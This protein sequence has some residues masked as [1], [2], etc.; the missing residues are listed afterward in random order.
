M[1]VVP[2]SSVTGVGGGGS[3]AAASPLKSIPLAWGNYCTRI[4]QPVETLAVA[5]MGGTSKLRAVNRVAANQ[6]KVVLP[7]YYLSQT[8]SGVQ[9]VAITGNI[10]LACSIEFPRGSGNRYPFLF[11]GVANPT[12]TA[13]AAGVG[14]LLESDV[15][16][17][18]FTMQSD[19]A[20]NIYTYIACAATGR[21]LGGAY[22]GG[23]SFLEGGEYSATTP[24]DKTQTGTITDNFNFCYCPVALLSQGTLPRVCVW[25]DSIAYGVGDSASGDGFGNYGWPAR[26]LYKTGVGYIKMG[27]PAER[28]FQAG[29][30]RWT[31]RL[32]LAAKCNPTLCILQGGTND[33]VVGDVTTLAQ[34]QATISTIKGLVTPLIMPSGKW[35]GCTLLPRT[36]STDAFVTSVNQTAQTNFTPLGTSLREAYNDYL[37]GGQTHFDYVL[38]S[39]GIVEAI[40]RRGCWFGSTTTANYSG[41]AL[42]TDGTHPVTAGV[43]V[44]FNNLPSDTVYKAHA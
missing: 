44:I 8:G 27:C 3:L 13:G 1:S 7:L 4:N 24:V 14:H 33:I 23:G 43:S 29:L 39:G 2:N 35:I 17:L 26:Y 18:P 32:A 34:M 16:T 10:S 42:V 30:G 20:F 25:G 38:N 41:T 36:T 15:L 11:S 22:S 40:E 12:V 6:F 31:T 5:A 9:E 21:F 19:T 28:M 37:M